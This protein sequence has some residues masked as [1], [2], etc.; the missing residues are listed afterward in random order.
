MTHVQRDFV[1]NPLCG[2]CEPASPDSV[3]WE[4]PDSVVL[5]LI[6]GL[7]SRGVSLIL[8]CKYTVDRNVLGWHERPC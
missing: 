8:V 5:I 6:Q 4:L 2:T 1:T 3:R 7:V